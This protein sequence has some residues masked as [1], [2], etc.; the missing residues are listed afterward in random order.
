MTKTAEI[1]NMYQ[2]SPIIVKNK[3]PIELQ[4]NIDLKNNFKRQ[5]ES[6]ITRKALMKDLLK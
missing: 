5:Q 3:I 2:K 1:K 6:D 4:S